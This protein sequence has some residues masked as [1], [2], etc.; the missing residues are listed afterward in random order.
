MADSKEEYENFYKVNTDSKRKVEELANLRRELRM[1]IKERTKSQQETYMLQN[2]VKALKTEENRALKKIEQAKKNLSHIESVRKD[3]LASKIF[4][5]ENKAKKEKTF[6]EKK[7]EINE[8]K[9]KTQGFLK[10]WKISLA[11]KNHQDKMKLVNE[12]R[13]IMRKIN[14]EKQEEEEK[15]KQLCIK[16]KTSKINFVDKKQQLIEDK[17]KKMRKEILDKLNAENNEQNKIVNSNKK[18]ETEESLIKENL[19][20]IENSHIDECKYILF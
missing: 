11:Q 9:N 7:N 17:K 3:M 1:K 16:V 13:N 14:I 15:N 2:K 5:E 10:S 18:L 12:R 8:A 19:K 4:Y 6:E 20:S